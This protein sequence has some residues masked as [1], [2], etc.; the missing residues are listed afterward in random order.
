M[1]VNPESILLNFF[2][3]LRVPVFTCFVMHWPQIKFFFPSQMSRSYQI[4]DCLCK[5]IKMLHEVSELLGFYA[6]WPSD[7]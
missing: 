4:L 1:T 5:I 6:K 7:G 2:T 3:Q